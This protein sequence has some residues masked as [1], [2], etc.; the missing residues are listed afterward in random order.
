MSSM[1]SWILLLGLNTL[2]KSNPKQ[3]SQ[4]NVLMT[5]FALCH[6]PTFPNK[7]WSS[8]FPSLSCSLTTSLSW[9]VFPHIG[10]HVSSSF[11]TTWITRNIAKLLLVPNVIV[12]HMRKMLP[13]MAWLCMVLLPYAVALLSISKAPTTSKSCNQENHQMLPSHRP[14]PILQ[15][16]HWSVCTLHQENKL[17]HRRQFWSCFC[18]LP[19]L[20]YD[21]SDDYDILGS[22]ET[23]VAPYPD[24]P[25]KMPGVQLNWQLTPHS[26]PQLTPSNDD[27]NWAQLAKDAIA[28]ADLQH[29]DHLPTQPEVID[30]EDDDAVPLLPPVK[31]ALNFLPRIT[32]ESLL[33]T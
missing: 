7:Y 6:I 11:I 23:P 20:P 21:W 10:V 14:L 1:L 17:T 8:S 30:A 19:S 9:W 33:P 25:T 18:R 3:V 24:I 2:R 29:A 13:P 15:I 12:R 5:S 22:D 31:Q 16:D 26:T 28:N 27:P 4:K 32:H